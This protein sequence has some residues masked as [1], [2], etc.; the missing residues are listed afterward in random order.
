MWVFPRRYAQAEGAEVTATALQIADAARIM[1]EAVKDK[2]YQLLP[3]GMHAA[4]YLRFKK[5]RLTQSSE[6]VWESGLDKLARYFPDLDLADFEPPVGTARVE[7]FLDDSYGH[8]SPSTYNTQLSIVK[9]FFKWAILRGHLHG[10]PTL[11]IERARER[12]VHRETF[13][14]SQ[15]RAI[16]AS[17]DSRRDQITLRLLLN[18]GLRKGAL[19]NIQFK[20]F[21]HVRKRL[22]IFTKGETVLPV[23]VPDPAFWHDLERHILDIE[24]APEHYLMAR[25]KLIPKVGWREFPD[26]GMGAHGLH[27]WWYAC[28]AKAGVVSEGTTSGEKMHKARHSAGQAV[29]DVTGNLKAVQKLLGHKSIR[30]TADTYV[31]WDLDQ[32]AQSLLEVLKHE[33]A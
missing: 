14:A 15:I 2:S 4:S 8:L 10:D 16:V 6:R 13:S 31:D 33:G 5:K 23:P 7:E 32:L 24:A 28:L 30:T 3:L 21:D 11:S 1:R 29:L 22:T 12:A 27:D 19:S 9:D 26:K 20:H 18:Y 17:Q 25:R